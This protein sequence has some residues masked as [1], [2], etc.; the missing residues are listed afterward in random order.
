MI[1]INLDA[2]AGCGICVSSCP[3]GA[4]E[5]E[6]NTP[7]I[8]RSACTDCGTCASECP[9]EAIARAEQ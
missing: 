4:I 7:R 6:N 3:Q 8:N 2:C 5:W 9:V 1:K